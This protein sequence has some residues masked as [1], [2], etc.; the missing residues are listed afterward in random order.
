MVVWAVTLTVFWYVT[1]RNLAAR[2][3][4]RAGGLVEFAVRYHS[5][6]LLLGLAAVTLV[7]GD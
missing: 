7:E 6:L 3:E 5:T 1:L 4:P 2:R